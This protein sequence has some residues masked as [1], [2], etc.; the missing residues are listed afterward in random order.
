MEQITIFD[1][2]E[3]EL[4]VT[5]NIEESIYILADGTLW[6]GEFDMGY[7]GA[8]HREVE[9]FTELDRYDGTEFWDA[10]MVT[11]GMVMIV[12]ESETILVHPE[13]S[14]TEQQE[15]IIRKAELMGYEVEEFV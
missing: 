12:P 11:M 1:L 14:V 8:E 6:G 15:E 2:L 4:E 9:I 13:H 5:E 3:E 7:R 10:V